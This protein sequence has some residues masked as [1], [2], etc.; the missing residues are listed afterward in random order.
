MQ[1]H[2]IIPNYVHDTQMFL[3]GPSIWYIPIHTFLMGWGMLLHFWG[4]LLEGCHPITGQCF[5]KRLA[6][7]GL[8][9]NGVANGKHCLVHQ[10]LQAFLPRFHFTNHLCRRRKHSTDLPWVFCRR[11]LLT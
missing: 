2:A 3:K 9:S 5:L 4:R 8:R 10:L 11:Q 1:N 7:Q 6:V